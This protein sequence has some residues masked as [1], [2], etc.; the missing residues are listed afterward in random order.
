[1]KRM[2][3]VVLFYLVGV[4][5]P[6]IA[7]AGRQVVEPAHDTQRTPF[8]RIYGPSLPPQGYVIFCEINPSKCKPGN[9]IVQRLDLT[10]SRLLELDEV[11]QLV[12]E[13]IA[14]MT[15]QEIYGVSEYWTL[16]VDRGDCEDYAL[17]KRQILMS[18]GWPKS[19]LLMTVVRDEN[20]DG[21]AVLTVR[22]SEGDFIADNRNNE[23]VN[24]RKTPYEYVMRQSYL[25]QQNWMRL[26]P[27]GVNS[28]S[29]NF[30]SNR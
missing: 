11:N 28:S 26:G 29:S 20:G 30:G 1:M 14:P 9:R 4:L 7:N 23:I 27:K 25:N 22:T 16:P 3:F 24:W 6:S 19:A 5:L 15:D 12:N 18:K 2:S 17:L 21:H 8:M 10:T 13:A